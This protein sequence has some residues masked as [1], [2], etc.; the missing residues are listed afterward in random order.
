M[1]KFLSVILIQC[2]ALYGYSFL[3][4]LE[5]QPA[6]PDSHALQVFAYVCIALFFLA[7]VGMFVW[8]W[9]KH[10]HEGDSEPNDQK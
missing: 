2:L 9:I 1:K 7:P 6:W 10:K 3:W 5:G 4:M 8:A